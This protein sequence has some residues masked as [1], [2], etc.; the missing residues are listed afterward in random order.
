[1]STTERMTTR[2]PS[3]ARTPETR[4]VAEVVSFV[5]SVLHALRNRKA[6]NALNNLEDYQL[7]DIG[8][9][10]RDVDV[11]INRSGMLDD[12]YKLLP[13]HLRLRGSRTAA[14]PQRN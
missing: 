6:M 5:K 4:L 11:A 8:L 10:R 2:A 1:M 9:T 12:P 3:A 7:Q 13:R 14:M